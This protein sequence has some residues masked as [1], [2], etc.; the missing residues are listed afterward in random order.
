[1]IEYNDKTKTFIL[2]TDKTCYAFMIAHDKF[3]VHLYY[4]DK[5]NVK[6]QYFEEETNYSIVPD[7]EEVFS[8]DTAMLEFSGF[9]VGDY[10]NT[11]V[12]ITGKC[13][14]GDTCFIYCGYK[15]FDGIV[16]IDGLPCAKN[17]NGVKTLE[18][19]L[20]DKVLS[21]NLYLYYTVY[22]D[23]DVIVR[24]VRIQNLG[25]SEV[26]IENCMSVCLDLK[27]SDFDVITLSGCYAKEMQRK[28]NPLFFGSQ[29]VFSRRGATS[30]NYNPFMAICDKNA[31]YDNGNVY[32]VNLLYSGDFI[33][34]AETSFVSL[35]KSE[36]TLTRIQTGLNS[37]NFSYKLDCGETFDTPQG[38]ITYASNGFNGISDNFHKFVKKYILPNSSRVNPIVLNTWEGCFFDINEKKL[39]SFA[40]ECSEIGIDTLV[41][42]DGWFG[43]RNNDKSSLGDWFANNEK[44]PDDI[45]EFAKKVRANGVNFG[46]WVE[47]EMISIDSELF[48]RKPEWVLGNPNRSLS[49]GRNQL[50]LD[51]ANP[52]VIDYLKDVLG[53]LFRETEVSYVK[54]D[55]NRNLSE[56]GSGYLP[57]ERQKE[58][59]FRYMQGVYSL[60]KWLKEEFPDIILETCSGGG[61][62]YDLGMMAFSSMIWCSDNTYPK[63]RAY[64]QSGALSAYPSCVMSAHISNPDGV[65]EDIDELDYRYAV[66]VQGQLGFEMDISKVSKTTKNRIKELI[67]DYKQLCDVI[68]QGE[69]SL[70]FNPDESE[71]LSFGYKTDKELFA[72]IIRVGSVNET[73][74]ILKLLNADANATYVERYSGKRVSGK[75][76]IEG[77]KVKTGKDEKFNLLLHYIKE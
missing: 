50:V 37:E 31:D 5:D 45:G 43:H 25:A 57:C 32:A 46:L 16:N 75:S 22:P 55:M 18:I 14:S 35:A 10:R 12:K 40:E 15:I 61:G 8:L 28:R 58:T 33:T 63:N 30:H 70:L 11:S 56:V 17:G 2:N 27:G 7:G 6:L 19:K 13:N 73:A 53:K 49:L 26:F 67:A 77:I 3:P 51:M 47:P 4:G 48:R 23:C 21:C 41:V 62:R 34:E 60:L 74:I 52:A 42:D 66:A 68:S 39:L 72:V 24:S 76:L 38:I 44:F 36:Y 65:C 20:Y 59:S 69:Y 9:G 29:K 64:I 1:M 71:F 54:W